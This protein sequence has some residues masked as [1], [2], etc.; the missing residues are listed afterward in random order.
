M[1]KFL[2]S[3]AVVCLM[4]GL[5][6]AADVV[7]VSYDKDTKEVKVKDD[8]DVVKTYK[9]T[10]KT[11]VTVTDKEGKTTDG[12]IEDLTRRLEFAGKGGGKGGMKLDVTTDGDTITS[13]KLKARGG[14]GKDKN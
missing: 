13:V 5:V 3:L 1:R 8:K 11:K 12:K 7:V 2:C 10:D 14:K 6:V 9:I 4:A